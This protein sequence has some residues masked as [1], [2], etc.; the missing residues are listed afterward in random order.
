MRDVESRSE[1]C[2]EVIQFAFCRCTY[3]NQFSANQLEAMTHQESPWLRAREGLK[4]PYKSS[5]KIISDHD[6]MLFYQKETQLRDRIF[7]VESI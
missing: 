6:I 3:Y 4:K 7:K 2:N 1:R 5:K